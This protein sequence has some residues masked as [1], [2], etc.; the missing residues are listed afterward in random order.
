MA[1]KKTRKKIPQENK[2]RAELQKEIMSCCPFCDNE[3]VGHFE[4]HHIDENPE[5]NN[6]ENLILLC[7]VCHS[8]IT[9][10]DIKQLDV[11]KKKIELLT[12]PKTKK[13]TATSDNSVNFNANVKNAVVGNGNKITIN[14]P[15]KKDKAI[16]N[17]AKIKYSLRMKKRVI[18]ELLDHKFIEEQQKKKVDYFLYRPYSKFILSEVIVRSIDDTTY[19]DVVK[20]KR[21]Q[22]YTWFKTYFYDLY[23]DGI[24]FWLNAGVG[25][26]VIMDE[27]DFWEPLIDHDDARKKNPKYRVFLAKEIGRIPYYNIVEIESNGDDYYQEPHLFCKFDSVECPFIEIYFRHDGIEKN[28]DWELEKKKQTTFPKD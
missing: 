14:Q 1:E 10:G 28:Y 21:E 17:A 9:K 19:P 11:Y 20:P 16:D 12:K 6:S 2:V 5:N 22:C 4:I 26:S 3:D 18:K 13:Q 27:N 23:N 24:E 25:T 15:K 8:K 7:P